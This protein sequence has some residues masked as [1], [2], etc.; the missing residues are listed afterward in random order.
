MVYQLKNK[1]TDVPLKFSNFMKNEKET[2]KMSIC[3]V[4]KISRNRHKKNLTNSSE[5]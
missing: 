2:V 4:K 3:G 1:G 5:Y